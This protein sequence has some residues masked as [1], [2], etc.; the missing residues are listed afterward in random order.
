MS[1]AKDPWGRDEALLSEG[2]G[3]SQVHTDLSS[4]TIVSCAIPVDSVII[5]QKG[6]KKSKVNN[7]VSLVTIS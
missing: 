6:I 5:A 4:T 1:Q 7:I 2:R 3:H